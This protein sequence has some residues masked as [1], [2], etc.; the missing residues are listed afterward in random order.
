VKPHDHNWLHLFELHFFA[1]FPHGISAYFTTTKINENHRQ[2]NIRAIISTSIH[3]YKNFESNKI[4][5]PT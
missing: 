3:S 2:Y 5:N 1:N 4:V